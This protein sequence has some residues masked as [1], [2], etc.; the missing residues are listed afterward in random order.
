MR[1]A[2]CPFCDGQETELANAFG[3]HASVASWWC[4]RCR[5]PFDVF[6]W[7]NHA[8]EGRDDDE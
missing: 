2:T 8:D 7:G 5:S 3:A 4:I 1:P 6:K